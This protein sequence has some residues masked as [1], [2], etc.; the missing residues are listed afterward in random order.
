VGGASALRYGIGE[1]TLGLVIAFGS[2][3]LISAVAFELVEEAFDKAG[4]S[5]SIALVCLFAGSA[6]FY[7][8]D[9]VID[10]GR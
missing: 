10:G 2:G 7:I 1:R 4:G 8:G 5:G 9:G 3:V 6:T